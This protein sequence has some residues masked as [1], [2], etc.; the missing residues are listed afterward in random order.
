MDE[1]GTGMRFVRTVVLAAWATSCVAAS[2][3]AQDVLIDRVLAGVDGQVVT[4]SDLRAAQ[5]LGFVRGAD[6]TSALDALIDRLLVMGESSR[7]ATAEPAST[8]IDARVAEL[9]NRIGAPQLEAILREGG[10][11]EN[12]LR[13]QVRDDLVVATYMSQRFAATAMP[14]DTEVDAYV[15]SRREELLAATGA[16]ATPADLARVARERLSAERRERLIADW[17][18]GLRRRADVSLRS[19][20]PVGLRTSDYRLQGS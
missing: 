9:R 11:S 17:V 19:L 14:T 7:Y 12:E 6:E 5:A 15:A 4:L 16:T 8:D 10:L 3:L 1:V 13:R 18:T 2:S 20:T